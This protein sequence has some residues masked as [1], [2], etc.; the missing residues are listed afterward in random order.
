MITLRPCAPEKLDLTREAK[1]N[2]TRVRLLIAVAIIT[3]LSIVIV[4]PHFLPTYIYVAAFGFLIFISTLS[5]LMRYQLIPLRITD[6]DVER[7]AFCFVTQRILWENVERVAEVV[8]RHPSTGNATKV[9]YVKAKG[10]T[11]QIT[12]GSR[13]YEQQKELLLQIARSRHIPISTSH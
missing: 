6:D 13:S 10:D 4:A 1:L 5:A 2:A 11:L 3:P 9:T 8:I 12:D 7:S